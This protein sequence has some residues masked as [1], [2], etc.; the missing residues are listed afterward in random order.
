MRKE[1]YTNI[2]FAGHFQIKA[3]TNKKF[4]QKILEDAYEYGKKLEKIFNLYD[5]DSILSRLNKKRKLKVPKEFIKLLKKA[6]KA[7]KLTSGDY[8]ITLGKNFLAR[9]KGERLKKLNCS[10]KDI[11]IKGNFV[12]LKSPDI[13]IDFGSI[14][15]G[16]IT[17]KIGDYLKKRKVNSFA[18]NSR[19]DILVSGSTSQIIKIQHPRKKGKFASV[20]VKNSGIATSGDYRQFYGSLDKSHILN[21]KEFISVTVI[22]PK[23]V[24]ADLLA[25]VLIVS[26]KDRIVR[27]LKN[28]K[29]IKALTIDKNLMVHDYNNFRK[30]KMDD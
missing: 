27:L 3:Y 23:L 14:A 21:K 24:D 22:A 1:E 7:S 6:I 28:N 19:G 25:T 9:K 26:N 29:K 17:D 13:L 16:Y 15:K 30:N 12:E 2:L 18:I 4:N 10:Y 11:K 20:C 5:K 8:D